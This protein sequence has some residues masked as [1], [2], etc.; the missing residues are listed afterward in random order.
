MAARRWQEFMRELK[1]GLVPP[2][3]LR[4]RYRDLVTI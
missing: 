1:Q 3:V 2:D 4:E